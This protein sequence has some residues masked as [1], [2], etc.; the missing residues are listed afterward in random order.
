MFEKLFDDNLLVLYLLKLITIQCPS[1]HSSRCVMFEEM[2]FS[3][4]WRRRPLTPQPRAHH[5]VFG[6]SMETATRYVLLFVKMVCLA[7]SMSCDLSVHCTLY[8][9]T[10]LMSQ[11]KKGRLTVDQERGLRAL[12]LTILLSWDT[13]LYSIQSSSFMVNMIWKL[14]S[15]SSPF[16][17]EGDRPH[18]SLIIKWMTFVIVF[19]EFRS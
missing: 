6:S 15:S 8:T 9:C 19:Q 17:V 12:F 2:S 14:F 11:Q 3:F 16:V 4:N 1:H 18:G 10:V 7:Y 13:L 5:S